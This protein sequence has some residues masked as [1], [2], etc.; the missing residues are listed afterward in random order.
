MAASTTFP[1]KAGEL[2]N[3]AIAEHIE[4]AGRASQNKANDNDI[5]HHLDA[6][7]PC[8]QWDEQLKLSSRCCRNWAHRLL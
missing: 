8:Q 1:V 5:L 4:N 7:R 6:Q 3:Y 2:V